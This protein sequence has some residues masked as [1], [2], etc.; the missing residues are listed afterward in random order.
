MEIVYRILVSACIALP[1]GMAC[2][3]LRRALRRYLRKK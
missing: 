2:R 3:L 1:I